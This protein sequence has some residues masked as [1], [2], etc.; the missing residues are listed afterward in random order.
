MY[1]QIS[2][3]CNTL[4]DSELQ[5]IINTESL[6]KYAKQYNNQETK[7]LPQWQGIFLKVVLSSEGKTGSVKIMFSLHK[8]YNLNKLGYYHNCNTFD[9][10]QANEAYQL[11]RARFS[12]LDFT[13]FR[14]N[15]LEI[16]V[17]LQMSSPPLDTM[18]ELSHLMSKGTK[19]VISN[20]VKW[21]EG[22]AFGTHHATGR[23]YITVWYNKSKEARKRGKPKYEVPENL[24]RAEVKVNEK[25]AA[26][27]GNIKYFSELF[28]PAVQTAMLEQAKNN[29]DSNLVFRQ[30]WKR[31]AKTTEE[32]YKFSLTVQ[33]LGIKGAAKHYETMYQE[34]RITKGTYLSV[35]R[36]LIN[37]PVIN[38]K[39]ITQ[40]DSVTEYRMKIR[41]EFNKLTTSVKY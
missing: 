24:L 22:L 7:D 16:G 21:R 39:A 40:A 11:L 41:A 10:K 17:T 5:K 34:K 37:Q 15:G 20:N 33:E 27:N 12:Y 2:I 30:Y 3:F 31:G 6:A 1:D 8:Y 35:Q 38:P 29:L 13:K 23:K 25:P 19:R 28:T 9:F 32:E 18:K 4:S 36:M 14:I 26:N